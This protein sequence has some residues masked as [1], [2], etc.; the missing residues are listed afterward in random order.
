MP[1]AAS[2]NVITVLYE[3]ENFN[4]QSKKTKNCLSSYT[5]SRTSVERIPAKGQNLPTK[6]TEREYYAD[7]F[8]T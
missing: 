3:Y 8:I 2:V 7:F 5:N 1:T 6:K 4:G